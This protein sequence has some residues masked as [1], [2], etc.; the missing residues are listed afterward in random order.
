MALLFIGFP[1]FLFSGVN[2]VSDAMADAIER[3]YSS[4]KSDSTLSSGFPQEIL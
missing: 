2:E 4:H 3:H 1:I